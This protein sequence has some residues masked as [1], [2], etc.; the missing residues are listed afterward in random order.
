MSKITNAMLLDAINGIKSEVGALSQRV[1]AL[2]E[3]RK[4]PTVSATGTGKGKVKD[5]PFTKH[6]GTVIMTTAAQAQAWEKRRESFA[7]K[8]A[9]LQAWAEKRAAYKPSQA[10]IDAIKANPTAIT[11]KVAKAQY[12]FVGTSDDLWNLK[13]GTEGVVCKG[14]YNR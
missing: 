10:L 7:N 1:T 3:N 8:E 6:D 14:T 4:K 9:N 12:A 11:T 5:T 2:E 13:Y